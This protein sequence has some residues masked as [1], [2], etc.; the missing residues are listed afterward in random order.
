M[1][2]HAYTRRCLHTRTRTRAHFPLQPMAKRVLASWRRASALR[3]GPPPN[4]RSLLLAV[5]LCFIFTSHVG[6][7][8]ILRR[9]RGGCVLFVGLYKS[10]VKGTHLEQS[11]DPSLPVAAKAREIDHVSHRVHQMMLLKMTEQLVRLSLQELKCDA[12]CNV[13][14]FVHLR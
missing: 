1:H 12:R 14:L 11:H 2:M 8:Q 9:A 13:T 5:G 4:I 10:S 7:P 6:E 3:I